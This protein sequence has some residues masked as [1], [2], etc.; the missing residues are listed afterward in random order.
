M[1]AVD[2]AGD[3]VKSVRDMIDPPDGDPLAP[4][5]EALLRDKAH[6]A[7]RRSSNLCV[8]SSE[9]EQSD[10]RGRQGCKAG[11]APN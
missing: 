2:S 4:N 6:G 5:V 11:K 8:R 1:V 10:S 9:H 7:R 3:E